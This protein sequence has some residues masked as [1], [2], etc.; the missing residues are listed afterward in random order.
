MHTEGI[1]LNCKRRGE[2]SANDCLVSFHFFAR[3]M[4]ML[5]VLYYSALKG[6]DKVTICARQESH[7]FAQG[8]FESRGIFVNPNS[9]SMLS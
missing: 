2:Q 9:W 5:R 3:L 4:I 7:V 1:L 6:L 8:R